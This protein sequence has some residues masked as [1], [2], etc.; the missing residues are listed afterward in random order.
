MRDPDLGYRTGMQ[1]QTSSGKGRASRRRVSPANAQPAGSHLWV[2][3]L[4]LAL[5]V[6][7][8]VG[9][10]VAYYRV[11][12]Q[13][14]QA[15]VGRIDGEPAVTI[16]DVADRMQAVAR[17]NVVETETP[18]VGGNPLEVLRSMMEDELIQRAAASFGV[19][20]HEDDVDDALRRRFVPGYDPTGADDDRMEQEFQE[21]YGRFLTRGRISDDEY[22]GL[23]SVQIL[24]EGMKQELGNRIARVAEQVEL[25]WIVLPAD[26]EEVGQVL[27]L[28]RAGEPFE[29]LATS[30]NTDLFF[31]NPS[32]PGYVGWVP[33][34]AFPQLDNHLFNESAAPGALIGPVYL[35]TGTYLIG[36][37]SAPAVRE[38]ENEKML[39]QLRGRA[40]Q[41]WID[42]EWDRQNVEISFDSQ[43]YEWVVDHVRDNLPAPVE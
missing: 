37:I 10:A 9:L 23:V 38:I 35:R 1:T 11:Y 19:R 40:L 43:D 34:G 7:I 6:A 41:A 29:S 22:R 33:R 28:L 12:V 32:R 2:G 16:G 17:L 26:F 39:E 14:A 24:R 4:V 27:A 30:L 31:T 42:E 36:I 3:L 20:I 5:L 25:A 21:A 18:T 13:P 15:W 8:V